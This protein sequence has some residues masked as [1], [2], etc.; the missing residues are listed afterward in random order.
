[1]SQHEVYRLSLDEQYQ[2]G[3]FE[4]IGFED[5]DHVTLIGANTSEF[6]SG[7]YFSYSAEVSPPYSVESRVLTGDSLVYLNGIRAYLY[8][9]TNTSELNA[10]FD[11]FVWDDSGWLGPDT[12][13]RAIPAQQADTFS[14]DVNPQNTHLNARSTLS[15]MVRIR[16]DT[17]ETDLHT[18]PAMAVLQHGD[19]NASGSINIT[20]VAYLV[21]YLFGEGEEPIP[22]IEAGD[23]NCQMPVNVIDLSNTV[24]YL[25]GGGD[26]PPCNPY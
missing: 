21:S 25:F 18:A 12:A 24:Q 26:P 16:N 20:D 8:E 14:F 17:T 3:V 11:V 6:S 2:S 22:I 5:Y 13:A 4:L 9:V 15:F 23:F 10:V 1:V 7:A 19:A